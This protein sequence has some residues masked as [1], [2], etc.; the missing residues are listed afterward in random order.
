MSSLNN[1]WPPAIQWARISVKFHRKS[2]RQLHKSLLLLAPVN[3]LELIRTINM[4]QV[5]RFTSKFFV[6]AINKSKTKSHNNSNKK[7][8]SFSIKLSI[9][10][11][12]S[13]KTSQ[14]QHRIVPEI[15][16]SGQKSN[17]KKIHY[18]SKVS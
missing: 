11:L 16:L 13:Q 9:S 6:T 7:T 4:L 1:I 17:K 14:D 3:H 12:L 10:I 8:I 15:A 18:N 2:I 5:V